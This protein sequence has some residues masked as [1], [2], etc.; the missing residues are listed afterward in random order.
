MKGPQLRVY[1]RSSAVMNDDELQVDA[2]NREHERTQKIH[3][4]VN[5]VSVWAVYAIPSA[6]LLAAAILFV[7]YLVRGE[8]DL[9][10]GAFKWAAQ[11][12]FGIFVGYLGAHGLN[13]K[14][15]E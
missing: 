6:L 7:Y 15:E 10:V 3:D 11:M 12:A 5:Q 9:L 4:A 2:K 1:P 14:K 8:M 13:S